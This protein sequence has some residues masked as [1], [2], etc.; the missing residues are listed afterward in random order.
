MS[1][2]FRSFAPST[3]EAQAERA[4]IQ[5]ML[6]LNFIRSNPEVVRRAALDRGDTAP[7]DRLLEVDARRREVIQAEEALRERRNQLG[8]LM[9]DSR[10]RTPELIAQARRIGDEVKT[11]S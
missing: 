9:S 3:A 8:K 7:I 11:L 2:C 6:E 10:H 5:K 1:F 4:P